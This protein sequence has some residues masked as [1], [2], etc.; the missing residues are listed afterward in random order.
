ME[1]E[2]DK[3]ARIKDIARIAGVSATTVSNVIH[4]NTR[5]VSEE[6][7][8]R[9]KRILEECGYKPSVGALML[10][11][12]GSKIIGVLAACTPKTV[13]QQAFTNL[14]VRSLEK[15]LAER[16]YYML[17][18]FGDS[19]EENLKFVS[20]WKVEGIITMGISAAENQKIQMR[21]RVPVVSIDVYYQGGTEVP[22]VGLDDF[23]GGYL[24]GTYLLENGHRK[25]LFLS[26][27]DVGV[28]HA[29]WVGFRRACSESGVDLT[30][31]EHIIF[32]PEAEKR[33]VFYKENLAR[34]ALRND[35][36][37]FAS[38]YY[39]MEAI[40]YLE[41]L[42]IQVPEE[43]SIAGFDDSEFAL[44]CRPRLTT[45]RQNIPAKALAAV[46]KLFSFIHGGTVCMKERLP[47][48]LIIRDS[49]KI[50]NN[51]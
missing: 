34:I 8:L 4:G 27:N 35:A 25:L 16:N 41:D 33:E 31:K 36:L 20:T 49:V 21:C 30:E 1:F 48:S 46:D 19:A 3:K 38:D 26:D 14:M 7:A 18:H 24:M 28:D 42:Q 44:L 47:V 37:F 12:S 45:V 22:N 39:A 32:P 15:E 40:G 50:N 29:R 17:L 6:T 2:K 13:E 23:G 9:I 5:K 10:S 43:V 11:G 51:K